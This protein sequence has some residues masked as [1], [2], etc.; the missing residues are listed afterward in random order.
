[1]KYVKISPLVCETLK[2]RKTELKLRK[3]AKLEFMEN[4]L[5]VKTKN[6]FSEYHE[7]MRS[8]ITDFLGHQPLESEVIFN[9]IYRYTKEKY[10]IRKFLGIPDKYSITT[11]LEILKKR[12]GHSLILN[13][14]NPPIPPIARNLSP[15]SCSLDIT[16]ISVRIF[17]AWSRIPSKS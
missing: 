13:L 7:P 17:S 9:E 1:M 6:Y 15:L 4:D 2:V 14:R 10:S 11:N 3:G 12:A 5:P 8:D 16:T